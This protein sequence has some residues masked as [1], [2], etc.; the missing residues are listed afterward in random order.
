MVS[1][2]SVSAWEMVSKSSWLWPGHLPHRASLR[3]SPL[4]PF[5]PSVAACTTLLGKAFCK[6]VHWTSTVEVIICFSG[7][8]GPSL[9]LVFWDFT[10]KCMFPKYSLTYAYCSFIPHPPTVWSSK[11]SS[12]I[13]FSQ[14]RVA[15]ASFSSLFLT[16]LSVF[17]GSVVCFLGI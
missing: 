7:F 12:S 9:V 17:L 6:W 3:D 5:P 2:S 15:L 14:Q 10:S 4:S 8:Q 1:N 13:R 11:P 16:F